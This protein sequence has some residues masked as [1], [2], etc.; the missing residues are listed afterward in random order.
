MEELNAQPP[1]LSLM[2]LADK[3]SLA[4]IKPKLSLAFGEELKHAADILKYVIIINAYDVAHDANL[5][6][7]AQGDRGCLENRLVVK[8]L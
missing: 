4:D 8:I 2:R 5:I 1:I 6:L 3:I 7:E